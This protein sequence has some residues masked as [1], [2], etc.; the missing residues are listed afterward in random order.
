[1]FFNKDGFCIELPVRV[2]MTLNKETKPNPT[3]PNILET[4]LFDTLMGL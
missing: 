4:Y 3:E 1:M 2:D